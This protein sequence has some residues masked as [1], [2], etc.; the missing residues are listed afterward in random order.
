V[1]KIGYHASHE[2]FSPADLLTFVGLAEQSG[3]EAAM[4][5]DHLYPWTTA[6][7]EGVG[8]AYAWLG[9]AL[10]ATGLEL[11]VVSAPGQRYHPVV[12]AQAAVT[13]AQMFPGRFWV[14]VGT[15]E[16]SNEHVTGEG[17]PDKPVRQTRLQEC[18]AVMRALWRGETVN[19]TGLVTV[20]NARVYT[21]VPRPPQLFAAAVTPQ[22]ARWAGGWADGL[23]TVNTPLDQVRAVVEAFAEGGGDGKPVR[24]QYHLSWAQTDAVARAQAFSQWRNGALPFPLAWDLETPEQIDAALADATPED[25]AQTFA[26][27]GDL[28]WHA[29]RIA[30]YVSLGFDQVLLHNVGRNQREFIDAFGAKVLPQ[31]ATA[32]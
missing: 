27:G 29:Q 5:S 24:L 2:Q 25:V 15:G 28:G 14:A 32:R 30:E 23:I 10:Q 4:C 8:Y 17:W 20:H 9:A 11:G 3:F 1:T 18:V 26:V 19:H 31:L 16:Y 12:L 7:T 21:T 6:P 22:T 13:L